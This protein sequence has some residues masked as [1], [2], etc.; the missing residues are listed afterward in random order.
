M[1][2]VKMKAAIT[3]RDRG[4]SRRA[5]DLAGLVEIDVG[6]FGA[7]AAAHHADSGLTVGEIA[8]MLEL[9]LGG[10][11]Q[12]S[13][14]RAWMDLHEDQMRAE[15]AAMIH[16]V[17]RGFSRKKA[18]TELG[19]RWAEGIREFILAGQVTPR[20][21]AATIARK[22]HDIPALGLT[23]AVVEAVTFRVKLPQRITL[24]AGSIQSAAAS[25]LTEELRVNYSDEHGGY[26]RE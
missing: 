10:Q 23:G 4:F 14:V 9:G 26:S 1:P 13:F 18:A 15:A 19:E 24:K 3:D 5:T 22:G 6:V 25:R 16:R 20:N 17:A 12:R 7:Q 8:T 21:A 11:V 2:S